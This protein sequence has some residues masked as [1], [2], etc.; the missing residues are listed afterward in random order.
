MGRDAHLEAPPPERLLEQL[1][2]VRSDLVEADHGGPLDVQPIHDVVRES[3]HH[4]R[5]LLAEGVGLNHA[6]VVGR[7]GHP[8][9]RGI[10]RGR[11]GASIHREEG[12]RDPARSGASHPPT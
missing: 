6:H 11:A 10:G 1:R 7:D 3:R 9:R 12:R 2:D 8:E 4:R 5:L